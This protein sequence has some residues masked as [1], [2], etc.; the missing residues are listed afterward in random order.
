MPG[1]PAHAQGPHQFFVVVAVTCF[2]NRRMSLP[3]CSGGRA[4]AQ[5]AGAV[6]SCLLQR[7]PSLALSGDGNRCSGVENTRI[8]PRA[9]QKV[10]NDMSTRVTAVT[11]CY[12]FEEGF[13]P[14]TGP[15]RREEKS[16]QC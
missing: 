13:K 14:V 10:G 12:I 6:R 8:E 11:V 15:G 9:R 1:D 4:A 3:I 5:D 7:L 2:C 16:K